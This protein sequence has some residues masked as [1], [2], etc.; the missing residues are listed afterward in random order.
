MMVM[1]PPVLTTSTLAE[2]CRGIAF[3]LAMI[4]SAF[5]GSVYILLPMVPLLFF[6]PKLFRR[7]VDRLIGF[8]LIMPSVSFFF[9]LFKIFLS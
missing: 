3:S 8:W 2:K 1:E 6:C 4:L 9:I 7:L 5:F